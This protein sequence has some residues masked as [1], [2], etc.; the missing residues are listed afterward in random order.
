MHTEQLQVATATGLSDF[1]LPTPSE[2]LA[3]FN[4]RCR[5]SQTPGLFKV[6]PFADHRGRSFM[7][8]M[9]G[10]LDGGQINYSV[11]HPTV[12]KA[13]HRHALQTDYWCVVHGIMRVGV[14]EHAGPRRWL[15]D[16]GES[17]PV[18]VVIPATLWHGV[19]TMSST[20]AGLLYYVD[21]IYNTKNPDEDR[22]PHDWQWNP[23][24]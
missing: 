5:R 17:S 4:K 13:W 23:W 6:Q 2:E 8:L 7:G 21:Q 9:A 10:V 20:D 11:Q 3:A 15:T 12:I 24:E 16:V 22:R 18:I 14:M 1:L 19:Q